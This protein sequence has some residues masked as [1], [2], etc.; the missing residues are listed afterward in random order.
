MPGGVRRQL[1]L[2]AVHRQPVLRGGVHNGVVLRGAD[3]A[4]VAARLRVQG[5]VVLRLGLVNG[6]LV[7]LLL[8]LSLGVLL[9]PQE[10]QDSLIG[11]EVDGVL[12]LLLGVLI[13]LLQIAAHVA[14]GVNVRRTGAQVQIAGP[15]DTAADGTGPA[16]DT[17]AGHGRGLHDGHRSVDASAGPKS[18][19]LLTRVD[20]LQDRLKVRPALIP[21]CAVRI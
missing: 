4:L 16:D 13:P 6:N 15:G 17:V 19:K 5:L 1:R 11:A 7:P 18:T 21:V 8:V 12:L 3:T 2:S 20:A 9:I 10:L 14:G